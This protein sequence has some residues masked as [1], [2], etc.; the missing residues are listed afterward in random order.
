MKNYYVA[1]I[2]IAFCCVE[3]RINDVPL[4][5]RNVDNE[6]TA[7]LPINHLIESSG[8]QKLD[9]T[10]SPLPGNFKYDSGAGYNVDIWQYDGSNL[11]IIPIQS[12]CQASKQLSEENF[13]LDSPNIQKNF[14]ADVSYEI[15]RWNS[16]HTIEKGKAT[17]RMIADFFLKIG[18]LLSSNRYEDY[19]KLVQKRE[20]AVCTALGLG[21]EHVA[22]R[23]KILFDNLQNGFVFKPIKGK[24]IIEYYADDRIV[25]ILDED[26]QSALRFENPENGQILAIELFVGFRKNYNELNII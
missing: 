15:S 24:K 16:C 4:L 23:N 14:I 5:K 6:I 26:M 20:E 1:K 2:S 7:L 12:V 17:S 21:I 3:I 9:V 25:T 18:E 10:V 13:L 22:E 8:V 19:T 11:K